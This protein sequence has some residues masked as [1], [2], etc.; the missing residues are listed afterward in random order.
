MAP[1]GRL[2]IADLL[3]LLLLLTA[4]ES[5]FNL[6]LEVSRRGPTLGRVAVR[7]LSRRNNS[8]GV[9]IWPWLSQYPV[10]LGN[11]AKESGTGVPPVLLLAN[12]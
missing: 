9:G 2:W 8:A 1:A 10:Q 6:L 7:L 3:L 4:F 12:G 5:G 11:W